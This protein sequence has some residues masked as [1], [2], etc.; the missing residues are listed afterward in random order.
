MQKKHSGLVLADLGDNEKMKESGFVIPQD[1]PIHSWMR[2]GL[3]AAS[4][5]YGIKPGRH[6]DEV[7]RSN[8]RFTTIIFELIVYFSSDL[9]GKSVM[10]LAHLAISYSWVMMC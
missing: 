1:I 5:Q 10:D 7:D 4:N 2:R 8:G 9:K 6:W 3:N